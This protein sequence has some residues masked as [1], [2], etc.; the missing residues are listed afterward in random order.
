MD[1][2]CTASLVGA[3]APRDRTPQHSAIGVA[4]DAEVAHRWND[5]LTHYP[6]NVNLTRSCRA[7]PSVLW[8]KLPDAGLRILQVFSRYLH[9]GGEELS[10]STHQ[11]SSGE[12]SRGHRFD[13]DNRN[14]W[15]RDAPSLP[16]Q[17]ARTLTKGE[18]VDA[19][20]RVTTHRPTSPFSSTSIH[21][22]P[23]CTMPPAG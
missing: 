19:L 22:S 6:F 18:A 15:G 2:R 1:G 5:G 11:P 8:G 23:P 16:I 4:K 3:D 12:G 21:R 20:T 7:T 10:I 17:A 13:L 9:L 14:G